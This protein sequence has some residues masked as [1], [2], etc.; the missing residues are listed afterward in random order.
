[1]YD[2]QHIYLT[3]CL[4]DY[5]LIVVQLVKFGEST[6]VEKQFAHAF[7]LGIATLQKMLLLILLHVGIVED[8][9]QIPMYAGSWCLQFVCGI[10]RQLPFYAQLFFLRM[11]QF[12]IKHDDGVADVAQLVIRQM[13]LQFVVEFFALLRLDGKLTQISNVTADAM[14]DV[15]KYNSQQQGHCTGKVYVGVVCLERT[16]QFG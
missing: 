4:A 11:A 12:P 2:L 9:F 6:H 13:P 5:V 10:L 3:I 15:V 16:S 14:G 1:M 8:A 7:T